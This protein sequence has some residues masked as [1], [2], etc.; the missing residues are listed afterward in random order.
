[1]TGTAP[2]KRYCVRCASS[3]SR[4]NRGPLCGLCESSSRGDL[5][6][7]PKL[8]TTFWQ[9]DQIRDAI[10]TWHMGRVIFTYRTHPYHGRPL[11]QELVGSWLGLTQAQLSRIEKGPAPEQ[12]FKLIRWAQVLGIPEQLLWFKLPDTEGDT[13]PS[14]N[15]SA[16][17]T[18]Q[19]TLALVQWL[20]S[21]GTNTPPPNHAGDLEH[22]G[23]ALTDAY[24]YFDGT[25]VEFFRRELERCKAD[26]GSSGPADVLPLTLAVIGAI[27]RHS[28]TARP[29]IGRS[30]LELGADGAEFAGWL[31]RDLH[32]PLAATVLYDRAMEWA[33]AAGSLPMQGYVLLKKSQMAYD[34][35]DTA[36]LLALA[37]A[38]KNGPW[39]LPPQIRAEVLQ[40]VALGLAMTG[41]P[42]NVVESS[43]D[44]AS[45]LL[46]QAIDEHDHQL[47]SY[48]SETTLLVRSA[49]CYI[50]AGKPHTA[51]DLFGRVLSDGSLSRRDAGFF[52]AR[53]A[54]ALALSGEPDEASR[55]AL[56]SVAVARDTGS[57]RTMNVVSDVVE[58]LRPWN[59]R[60]SVRELRDSLS[61][62]R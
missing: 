61:P 54:K 7:P 36:T 14:P 33:Q 4:Y 40:Q 8:P 50:A 45:Q 16:Q 37:H 23:R 55:V 5:A 43:L 29:D 49:C 47:V 22:V 62:S 39:Q 18:G 21:D 2:K 52:G 60:P 20:V 12:L 11:P 28:S 17:T 46:T 31:Y 48:F 59:H 57:E 42:T 53:Q 58:T 44:D 10:A 19:E 24:R 30:L 32:D 15:A 1:M 9:T 26:D 13:A 41:E 51:I 34:T 25:V 56:N 3:L 35:R 27:R 38:A 6:C